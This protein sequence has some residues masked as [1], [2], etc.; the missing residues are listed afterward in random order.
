M[1]VTKGVPP[2]WT[3]PTCAKVVA[4]SY[5][6]ECG[7]RPVRPGDLTLQG[8]LR[9]L[10]GAISSIDGR[11]IRSLRT[12]VSRPGALTVAWVQGPRKPFV[13]PIQ[14]FLLANVVFVAAQSLTG[15]NVFSSTLESH[16]H[17]QDWRDL[18]QRLVARHLE[19][20]HVTLE[21]YAPVF[22]R[23]VA[24]H[25]KSLVIVMAIPFA[26]L[27]PILFFR[28]RRPFVVHVVFAV[29]VYSFILLLYCAAL[30]V[31]A[32]DL[33]RSGAGLDSP[34]LDTILT[35]VILAAI[36]AYLYAAIGRVFGAAGATR[37][38]TSLVLAVAILA[39][40]LAYR[41]GLLLLTL[42]VT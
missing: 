33:L 1:A 39:I 32:A 12:L 4:T 34:R 30:A 9:Q 31:S 41:F 38:S 26:I 18:A 36:T 11:I 10:L 28:N 35:V 19:S 22:N 27:L 8:L 2:T 14:L 15:M 5:C 23:A 13:G 21:A 25:A 29:H 24:L 20:T 16:L 42:Y 6:P 7:E 3:C 17:H 40:A 37:I